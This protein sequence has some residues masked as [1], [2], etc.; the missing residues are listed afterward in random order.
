MARLPGASRHRV[1]TLR[2]R[3]RVG[4]LNEAVERFP[5]V[6]VLLAYGSASTDILVLLP[7][8][9]PDAHDLCVLALA[10]DL[11]LQRLVL[12]SG[13]QMFVL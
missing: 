3:T 11:Y 9:V 12:Y 4:L 6:R 5:H 8:D 1:S 13:Q 2:F 7:V 10:E